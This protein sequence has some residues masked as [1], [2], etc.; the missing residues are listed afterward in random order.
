[1]TLATAATMAVTASLGFWQLGRAAQKTEYQRQVERQM[2]LPALHGDELLA[3]RGTGRDVIHRPAMLRGSWV[4]GATVFLDNR[5]MDGQAGFHVVT[6]LRLA[7]RE[8]SVLVVRGWAP[9]DPHDRTRLP[10]LSTPEGEV[11]V[12]GRLAP[13]PS[14]LFELGAEA[15][16]PIRQNIDIDAFARETGLALLDV[17]LLQTGEAADGLRREW[18]R[19]A[20]DV[21]KHH[22]YAFQWFGL[23]A[24]AGFLYV[25]FQFIHPRLRASR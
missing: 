15:P 21:H 4:A 12:R 19:M 18:P 9:R 1:M 6:P 3:M 11:E 23:C 7:G 2:A 20:A 16:G 8:A 14:R 25:W 24:L 13:P 22:G 10:P 17:S 5:P